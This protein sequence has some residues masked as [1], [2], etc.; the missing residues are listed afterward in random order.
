MSNSKGVSVAFVLTVSLKTLKWFM[1]YFTNIH[2]SIYLLPLSRSWVAEAKGE[3]ERN[4]YIHVPSDPFQVVLGD[5]K[6]FAGQRRYT[7]PPASYGSSSE[8]PTSGSYPEN[9]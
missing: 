4:P 7:I 2:Q 5:P 6:A 1:R 8:P 3:K 9:L